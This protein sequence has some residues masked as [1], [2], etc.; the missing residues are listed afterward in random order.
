[1]NGLVEVKI[2]NKKSGFRGAEQTSGPRRTCR[3]VL[4]TARPAVLVKEQGL[5]SEN[6]A[7]QQTLAGSAAR[8][9]PACRVAA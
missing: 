3:R 1:M 2:R 6:G 5:R 8:F 4:D 7:S 9:A